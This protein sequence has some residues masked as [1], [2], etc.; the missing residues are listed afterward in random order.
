MPEYVVKCTDC[1][2]SFVAGS[3]VAKYCPDCR[4]SSRRRVHREHMRAVRAGKA[5][6][7]K[8][9]RE[10]CTWCGAT[11]PKGVHYCNEA[12]RKAMRNEESRAADV[13][14]ALED[15]QKARIEERPESTFRAATLAEAEA[16]K[17]FYDGPSRAEL[18]EHALIGAAPAVTFHGIRKGV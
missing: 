17:V 1:G 7:V 3:N 18:R 15:Q 16:I 13:L 9:V 4:E 10:G 14:K 11:V 2:A 5:R 12:C 8:P 6:A